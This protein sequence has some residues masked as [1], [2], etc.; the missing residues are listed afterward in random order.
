MTDI[1]EE[2]MQQYLKSLKEYHIEKEIDNIYN[3]Y[4]NVELAE[5][6]LGHFNLSKKALFN[7]DI[8]ENFYLKMI[9]IIPPIGSHFLI[10]NYN[11][12]YNTIF[13]K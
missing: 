5:Y 7:R 8:F 3:S 2:T 4:T 13:E 1:S 10:N 6:F 12:S 9:E 11:I